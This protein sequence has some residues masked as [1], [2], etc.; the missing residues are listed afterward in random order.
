MPYMIFGFM[1]G[2]RS[3]A[4][5]KI[6]KEDEPSDKQDGHKHVE[7]NED[8]VDLIPMLRNIERQP[9]TVRIFHP[10]IIYAGEK[11]VN[12]SRKIM[13]WSP[14]PGGRPKPSRGHR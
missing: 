3:E 2:P 4:D 5:K 9:P 8:V 14:E 13:R 10:H 6:Y 1:A 7:I 11:L 12:E